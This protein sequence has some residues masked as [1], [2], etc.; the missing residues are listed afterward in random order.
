MLRSSH[1]RD[2]IVAELTPLTWRCEFESRQGVL[3][4]T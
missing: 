4:T 1:G 3:N 2:S